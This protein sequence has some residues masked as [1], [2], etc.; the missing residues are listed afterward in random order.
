MIIPMETMC[1][2]CF[3]LV[4]KCSHGSFFLHKVMTDHDICDIT[5]D[6]ETLVYVKCEKGKI[7][8]N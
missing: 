7:R 2:E 5:C 4:F 3:A 8:K 1:L 6:T